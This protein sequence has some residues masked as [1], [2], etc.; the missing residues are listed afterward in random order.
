MEKGERVNPR[1]Y[2]IERLVDHVN[3]LF[4]YRENFIVF[5]DDVFY[6]EDRQGNRGKVNFKDSDIP[7]RDEPES[8]DK[9]LKTLILDHTMRS[10]EGALE[11]SDVKTK[12]IKRVRE[13]YNIRWE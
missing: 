11:S 13:E 2:S 5:E 4:G 8:R 12:A 3:E 1:D 7:V 9:Y 10:L 6:I